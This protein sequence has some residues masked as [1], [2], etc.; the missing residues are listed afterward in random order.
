MALPIILNSID[1]QNTKVDRSEGRGER[2]QTK[3][4]Q[5]R[6]YNEAMSLCHARYTG[7]GQCLRYIDAT[8]ASA[9]A[10]LAAASDNSDE[11]SLIAGNNG[12]E[13]RNDI[14][15]AALARIAQGKN[16]MDDWFEAFVSKPRS[17]LRIALTVDLWMSIGKM[18][19][20]DDLPRVF[21]LEDNERSDSVLGVGVPRGLEPIFDED[22]N[23][24]IQELVGDVQSNERVWLEGE[25]RRSDLDYFDFGSNEN[26]DEDLGDRL[27]LGLE[28]QSEM[29]SNSIETDHEVGSEGEGDSQ[30]L[31]H[32]DWDGAMVDGILEDVLRIGSF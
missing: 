27:P 29:G 20:N 18:A 23:G 13:Q 24:I 11:N 10:D 26:S 28:V 2:L 6:L 17:Y 7:T 16:R 5:L 32:E 12:N 25:K 3:R 21:M 22:A 8:I 31:D 30:S 4:H 19:G 15:T 9:K 14:S 1:L